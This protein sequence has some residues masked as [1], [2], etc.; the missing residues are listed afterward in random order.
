VKT[1]VTVAA[2]AMALA[3]CGGPPF[4]YSAVQTTDD[5]AVGSDTGPRAELEASGIDSSSEPDVTTTAPDD[6]GTDTG[7]D[8]GTP[9]ET[10]SGTVAETGPS[11]AAHE[12][13]MGCTPLTCTN[14][15][16]VAGVCTG[17][18]APTQNNPVPCG[19]CGTDIQTCSS[20]GTWVTHGCVGQ[21]VC[22]PGATQACNTY[23]MQS[24]TSTCG[25]GPCSCPA[26]PVCNPSSGTTCVSQSTEN[27]CDACGQQTTKT[28]PGYNCPC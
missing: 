9:H 7:I 22:T 18:C 14:Q 16:C 27:I 3:A 17:E 13:S 15:T 5:G 1:L 20:T 26:A 28:C 11:D 19:N 8:T 25:W 4:S 23:G 24:C 21:G 2:T 10:D 12:T 6:A